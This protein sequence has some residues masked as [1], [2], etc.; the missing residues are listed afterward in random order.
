MFIFKWFH[1]QR[2]RWYTNKY[3]NWN[4]VEQRLINLQTFGI[5]HII[6]IT[7]NLE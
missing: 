1:P 2:N 4:K 5:A 3:T 7:A 6:W